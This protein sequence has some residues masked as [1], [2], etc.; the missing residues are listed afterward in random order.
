MSELAFVHVIRRVARR[1][2]VSAVI[3]L[4]VCLAVAL[5]VLW[6]LAQ[7][8][9]TLERDQLAAALQAIPLWAMIFAALMTAISFFAMALYEDAGLR[10]MGHRLPLKESLRGGFVATSLGQTLGFGMIVGSFARWRSY[11]RF[12]FSL[13]QS[14]L[15]SGIVI[16]GFIFGFMLVVAVFTLIDPTGLV[17]L[18]STSLAASSTLIRALACFTILAVLG[19]FLLSLTNARF[20]VFGHRIEAPRWRLLC[21][22][23]ILAAV[24]TIPAA[25]ALWVLIP[26]SD[27][28]SLFAIIPVYLVA[29]GLGL[30]SN[31]PG[32][33]GVLELTCL[34]ALPVTPPEA[35]IAA[36]IVF[37]AI[38]YGLPVVLGLALLAAREMQGGLRQAQM[39]TGVLGPCPSGSVPPQLTPALDHAMRA[40]AGL[41]YA[42]DKMYLRSACGKAFL[43]FARSGNSLIAI[44]DPVG[45]PSAWPQLVARFRVEAAAQFCAPV[46][47]KA[48]PCFAAVLETSDMELCQISA[49]AEIF[50]SQF[51]LEGSSRRELRRKLRQAE[52]AG[53]SFKRFDPTRFDS[54]RFDSG[55]FD[56]GRFEPQDFARI[57]AAWLEDRL[58]RGFSMGRFDPDYLAGHRVVAAYQN[59]QPL[60][61]VSLWTSGDG[62]EVSIDVTRCDP[63][64][65][66]GTMHALCHEALTW[67]QE[68]GAVVFSLCAAPFT[69]PCDK[70]AET[71]LNR[72]EALL[73]WA[74][75]RFPQVFAG[76]GLKRF[77]DAFRPD[78]APRY[79]A[80]PT[81]FDTAL[82]G[83]DAARLIARPPAAPQVTQ[84]QHDGA[85]DGA[86]NPTAVEI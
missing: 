52:K 45:D 13:P 31:S 80:A 86:L 55:R 19:V 35:L 50:L 77:K 26:T 25:I 57:A 60:G 29:L 62:T 61:F 12:G 43:M 58:E 74:H 11:R 30:M 5:P 42:G 24:D 64:A 39:D 66:A 10:V 48:S 70:D 15:L 32:G 44:S 14:A 17:I 3:K 38:Y 54:S 22:N 53:V 84:A 6:M 72:S 46:F 79:L 28:P 68:R 34:M 1:S 49:E 27:A 65:P 9:E 76:D 69:A 83:L 59:G 63:D 67:A 4:A 36:L 51:T 75:G 41:A 2:D 56:S 81:V 33:V 21:R 82:G 71:P 37:R 8:L 85:Q 73:A 18:T 40:E 16:A 23:I 47:Y 78:W 20:Q 7:H